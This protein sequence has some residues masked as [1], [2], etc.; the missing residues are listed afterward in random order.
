MLCRQIP[1]GM[2]GAATLEGEDFLAE[3]QGFRTGADSWGRVW[4]LRVSSLAAL[5]PAPPGL[6]WQLLQDG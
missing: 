3:R 6:A 1:T 5:L 4:L 2:L